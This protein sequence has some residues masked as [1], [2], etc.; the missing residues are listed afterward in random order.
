[1]HEQ[2]EVRESGRFDVSDLLSSP[3]GLQGREQVPSA[4][5]ANALAPQ[6]EELLQLE[7]RMSIGE[8]EPAVT[9]IP[10]GL[11]PEQ[12]LDSSLHLVIMKVFK[13]MVRKSRET[14]GRRRFDG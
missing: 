7:E 10:G 3:F 1:M 13:E 6:G 8:G 12:L 2:E 14:R 4:E 11:G 9:A 5:R